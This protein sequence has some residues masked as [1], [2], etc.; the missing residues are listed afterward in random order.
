MNASKP[1][2][3]HYVPCS[4]LARFSPQT[5]GDLRKR[6]VLRTD[7]RIANRPVAVDTQCVKEFYYEEEDVQSVEDDLRHLEDALQRITKEC[8]DGMPNKGTLRLLTLQHAFMFSRGEAIENSSEVTKFGAYNMAANMLLAN[9]FYNKPVL[10]ILDDALKTYVYENYRSIVLK[11]PSESLITSDNPVVVFQSN[12]EQ[13]AALSIMPLTSHRLSVVYHRDYVRAK[14]TSLTKEDVGGLNALQ[15][16]N[17][18]EA[19]FSYDEL[20]ERDVI[21]A[22]NCFGKR[23]N[24]RGVVS[25]E[26]I[27]FDLPLVSTVR[28]KLSFIREVY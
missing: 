23:R 11:S 16:I 22:R 27:F 20:S 15:S 1:K 4:Y 24:P 21:G 19:I 17:S 8:L 13:L 10:H 28:D 3:Q 7:S 6:R 12:D 2:K 26:G 5:T 25:S 9:Y 18:H 14:Q